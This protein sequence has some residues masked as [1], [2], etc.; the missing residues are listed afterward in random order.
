[1][2]DYLCTVTPLKC[3]W[4]CFSSVLFFSF[5]HIF[6]PLGSAL[7]LS[8]SLPVLCARSF[9]PFSFVHSLLYLLTHAQAH[10]QRIRIHWKCRRWLLLSLRR[11][12]STTIP[13]ISD[14]RHLFVSH[15]PRFRLRSVLYV[16]SSSSF[17]FRS[18]GVGFNIDFYSYHCI[19][20][21]EPSNTQSRKTTTT[22]KKPVLW[23]SSSC[24]SF[25]FQNIKITNISRKPNI[26]AA[27][28]RVIRIIDIY[29]HTYQSQA[30]C[31]CECMR[32]FLI[33]FFFWFVQHRNMS[34]LYRVCAACCAVLCRSA[35]VFHSAY[36]FCLFSLSL[37]P[38]LV[39]VWLSTTFLNWLS[40][41]SGPAHISNS[42]WIEINKTVSA[43]QRLYWAHENRTRI[44]FAT[45]LIF[46]FFF[47]RLRHPFLI[48][49]RWDPSF[50]ASIVTESCKL[51]SR[52]LRENVNKRKDVR[53][54]RG[55]YIGSV[56]R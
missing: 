21:D 41:V 13:K 24:I 26:L 43:K 7:F 27:W 20:E 47:V 37:S 48:Q 1:M 9:H 40:C 4:N 49:I 54:Q 3:I 52:C 25:V 10:T 35:S 50:R 15:F 31:I 45:F 38:N 44:R 22:T 28:V 5:L 53:S 55:K 12:Q 14:S 51:N 30:R 42:T 19:R 56:V 33:L 29:I 36:Q 18:H 46:F 39:F 23:C 11:R 2:T 34:F 6:L 17:I 8:L 16:F 32:K